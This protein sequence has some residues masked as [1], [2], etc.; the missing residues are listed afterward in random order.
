MRAEAASVRPFRKERASGVSELDAEDCSIAAG[1]IERRYF[2]TARESDLGVWDRIL[3]CKD[4]WP[5]LVSVSL[6]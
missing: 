5:R 3:A 1:K 4:R 6:R 2:S